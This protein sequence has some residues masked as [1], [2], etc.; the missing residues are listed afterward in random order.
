MLRLIATVASAAAVLVL[1]LPVEAS[2][3]PVGR[4]PKGPVTSVR[5]P[6]GTFVSVTLPHLKGLSWRLARRFDSRV[7]AQV[8][9][10]DIGTTVVITYRAKAVGHT[11]MIYA[12]TRGESTV[13][14][15]ART[16]DVTVTR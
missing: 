2:A 16:L 8:G 14:R 10:G 4:L 13:A 11:K 15:A 9:E 1:A 6:K 7:V 12:A 5:T 3:P